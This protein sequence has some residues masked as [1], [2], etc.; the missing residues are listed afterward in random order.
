M[1]Q[2]GRGCLELTHAL[3]GPSRRRPLHQHDEDVLDAQV[4]LDTHWSPAR[5]HFETFLMAMGQVRAL[6]SYQGPCDLI[7][8]SGTEEVSWWGWAV[9]LH[10]ACFGVWAAWLLPLGAPRLQ[11]GLVLSFLL[12][13]L[14]VCGNKRPLH[15][16]D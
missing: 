13:F 10:T 5:T 8:G 9:G 14:S 1:N 2:Y 6:E 7:L 16:S 15:R 3:E 11:D 4:C 12:H